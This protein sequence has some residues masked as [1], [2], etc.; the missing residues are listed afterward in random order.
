MLLYVYVRVQPHERL[1]THFLPPSADIHSFI[2]ST[3]ERRELKVDSLYLY[4]RE[5]DLC[6]FE[7][8]PMR[9]DKFHRSLLTDK[10][11]QICGIEGHA[12]ASWV[13]ERTGHRIATQQRR[14]G[15]WMVELGTCCWRRRRRRHSFVLTRHCMDLSDELN[16]LF[17]YSCPGD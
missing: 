3:L 11:H 1:A 13:I 5:F 16:W 6:L 2:H 9:R 14:R 7:N 12:V 15:T 4:R 8:H 10:L 17:L